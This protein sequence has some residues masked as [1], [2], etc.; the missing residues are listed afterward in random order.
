[1]YTCLVMVTSGRLGLGGSVGRFQNVPF[2]ATSMSDEGR[3]VPHAVDPN[4]VTSTSAPNSAV[5]AA[6]ITSRAVV[7]RA[8]HQ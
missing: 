4:T 3:V 8:D 5:T 6:V 2:T 1:M 7:R